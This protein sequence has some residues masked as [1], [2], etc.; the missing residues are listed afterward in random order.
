[1][2]DTQDMIES[3]SRSTE[4]PSLNA[5]EM[6]QVMHGNENTS[7]ISVGGHETSITVANYTD[8]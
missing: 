5:T 1:M 3:S 2:A 4:S 7:R 8:A 6:R